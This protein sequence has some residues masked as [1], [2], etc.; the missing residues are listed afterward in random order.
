LSPSEIMLV[1]NSLTT[2][3]VSVEASSAFSLYPNPAETTVSIR[4]S[5]ERVGERYIVLDAVGRTVAQGT[6]GSGVTSVEVE[7]L[8]SGVYTIRMGEPMPA[9]VQFVKR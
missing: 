9:A 1:Y 2:G 4:T 6:L 7:S 3:V 5:A 8:P